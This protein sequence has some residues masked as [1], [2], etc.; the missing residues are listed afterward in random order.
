MVRTTK[1]EII[2][3]LDAGHEAEYHYTRPVVKRNGELHAT[4]HYHAARRPGDGGR[5]DM[6]VNL[7]AWLMMYYEICNNS[8][9]LYAAGSNRSLY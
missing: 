8:R 4:I 5:P 7:A 3:Y 2:D 9:R 6:R 1:D